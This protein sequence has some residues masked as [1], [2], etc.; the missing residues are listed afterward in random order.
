LKGK[1][2]VSIISAGLSKFGKLEGLYAREIFAEAA[3]EAFDR[4]PKLNPKK[5]IQTLFVGHMGESYEHQGHTGATV[6][7]WAG[8]LHIPATRTETACAS[9]AAAL[10]AGIFAVLSGLYNVVMVGGVEKM[11]HRTTPEVT[12][13]LAMASD[14]PFE[15]W[16]GITF[17]GLYALMAT[18]HMHKYRTT[19][20]QL[21]MVAVKNHHNGFL[22][23]KA[24][25]QREIT[26]EKALSSRVI[27]W[28]LKLYDCSLITDG[29][30]CLIITKPEIAKKYTDMPIHIIGSGQASD[31]IGI[32]ERE[33]FT[34]LIAAKIAAKQAY[35]MAGANPEDI[36]IAEAHDCFTIAEIIAYEDLGFCKPGEGGHLIEGGETRL[37]GRLPV[38]TSGGLKS[39][40]HPVGA[41]GTAQPY[42][43][44]LQL[45]EQAEK[46]QVKDA[47][48]GLAHN[49]GG[50]GATAAVHIFRRE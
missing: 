28:P 46:R 41:T 15:Q 16:H 45:T 23:P 49:V 43:I 8:L 26:L 32:Y 6:A 20:E 21:A 17:P 48:I 11:T 35:E 4:C 18:A 29:A 27:A 5:D 1:P 33:S 36:D 3:K 50:S 38:N 12:E 9:S 7:D 37:D 39:K 40:G 44:Y 25:M 19:E 22:N 42:E 31:S 24:H 2:L 14:F 10:R 34:S 47:K 30:S 13:F